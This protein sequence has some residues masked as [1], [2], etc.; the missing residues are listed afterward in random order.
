ML[1]TEDITLEELAEGWILRELPALPGRVFNWVLVGVWSSS[2]LAFLSSNARFIL[3]E[4]SRGGGLFFLLESLDSLLFDW[5]L[6]GLY[7]QNIIN[8]IDQGKK[9]KI[10][11]TYV[12]EIKWEN[13]KNFYLSILI[14]CIP[15]DCGRFVKLCRRGAESWFL[16]P[17]SEVYNFLLDVFVNFF[18]RFKSAESLARLAELASKSESLELEAPIWASIGVLWPRAL[19]FILACIAVTTFSV[20]LSIFFVS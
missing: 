12:D 4:R 6:L 2:A 15:A 16:N 19:F 9:R 14:D 10:I 7:K 3:R 8:H 11:Y 1:I 13:V 20:S 18:R 17:S 5:T